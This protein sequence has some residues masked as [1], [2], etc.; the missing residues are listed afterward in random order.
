MTRGGEE[1]KSFSEKKFLNGKL[2]EPAF[3]LVDVSSIRANK[4]TRK[5]NKA[6][7]E[8][9]ES[10]LKIGL[11]KPVIVYQTG[12]DEYELLSNTEEFQA[13]TRAKEEAPRKREMVNAFIVTETTINEAKNQIELLKRIQDR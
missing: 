4:V 11:L 10:I 1:Q 3:K 8:L 9:Q 6:V 12:I 7:E 13:V 2:K 5:K